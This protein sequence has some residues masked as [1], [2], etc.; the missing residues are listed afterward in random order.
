MAQPN[1]RLRYKLTWLTLSLLVVGCSHNTTAKNEPLSSVSPAPRVS[2]IYPDQA[3]EVVR[4]DR[5]TLVD[6][7]PLAAQ[8]DPLN[9][10]V[11]IT[12]PTQRVRSVGD[13]FRYILLESGYSLCSISSSVFTELLN[14][15]LPGVQRSIGPLRLSDALQILA[16]PAW[17]LRVDDVNREVCFTLRDAYQNLAVAKPLVPAKVI[18]PA[19]NLTPQSG[20]FL[21]GSS[22]TT[23][24]PVIATP[25]V[26][27]KSTL[28]PE[29]IPVPSPVITPVGQLWR[30]EVGLTLKETLNRWAGQTKCINGGNWVVIWP[31]LLDYRIDAPLAFHGNFESVLVQVFELYRKAD[32]PLFAEASRLQCLVAVS[33]IP[34]GR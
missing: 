34:G 22:T 9:Q 29:N 33:D 20:N 24:A 26:P 11:D 8:R 27:L 4:Y 14:K 5:Y 18:I 16:G 21:S 15:P 6:S 17:R 28:K 25:L 12:M 30:A 32:K 1:L 3:P 10:M 2:D 7:K 19:K 13:G 31:V 23:V